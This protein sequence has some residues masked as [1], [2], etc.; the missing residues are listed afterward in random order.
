MESR[1]E[2]RRGWLAV[3]EIL[4]RQ[5]QFELATHIERFLDTMP[6]PRTEKEQIAIG[7]RNNARTSR[8]RDAISR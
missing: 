8:G 1:S 2:V 4:I 3:G 5:G 7:V 6:L